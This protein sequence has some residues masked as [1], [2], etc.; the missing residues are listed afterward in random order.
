MEYIKHRGDPRE[1]AEQAYRQGF[2]VEAIQILHSFLENQA[3]SFFMLIGSVHFNAEQKDTWDIADSFS[4]HE[5]LK[6]LFVL[7]QITKSEFDE[8]NKF[9]SLRNKVVHQIF[10]EPYEEIHE[11]VPKADYDL[12]FNRTLDQIDFFTRKTEEIIA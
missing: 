9:N 2:Y 3:R 6:A 7:N 4:F 12:L 8:F 1:L 10:K 11:G 5:C